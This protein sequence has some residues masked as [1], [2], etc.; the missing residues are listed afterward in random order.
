M[1][2]KI[3]NT[4]TGCNTHAQAQSSS[5]IKINF[6]KETRPKTQADRASFTVILSINHAKITHS[7]ESITI[8]FFQNANSPE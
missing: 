8:P 2:W 6:H 4:E 1:E 3:L 5:N 7:Y